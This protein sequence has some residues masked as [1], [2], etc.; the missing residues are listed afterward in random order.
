[1]KFIWNGRVWF[2]LEAK[3]KGSW[4]ILG[5]PVCNLFRYNN[6]MKD[7][8]RCAIGFGK[9]RFPSSGRTAAWKQPSKN[10][11]IHYNR[12][13]GTATNKSSLIENP[14]CPCF[15][16]YFSWI[17]FSATTWSKHSKLRG[18]LLGYQQLHTCFA[19]KLTTIYQLV[20]SAVTWIPVDSSK[21]SS[22][23]TRRSP[24]IKERNTETKQ[25]LKC[26]T[27]TGTYQ[28]Y[29]KNIRIFS[30]WRGQYISQKTGPQ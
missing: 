9:S 11:C 22:T 12:T 16:S 27:L 28:C 2:T 26:H 13:E 17:F 6:C 20:G 25:S 5:Q 19:K 30:K 3:S 8:T 7:L 29:C 4:M 1:M 10:C 14:T 21:S 15:R 23:T 24:T 18:K